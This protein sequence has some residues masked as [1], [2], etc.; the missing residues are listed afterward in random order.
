[1]QSQRKYVLFVLM[2]V[3][4]ASVAI[5]PAHAQEN[6]LVADVPFD[7]TVGSQHLAAGNYR[8]ALDGEQ[9]S[10]ITISQFGGQTAY[11]IYNQGG[12]SADRNGKPYLI[13]VR[14]GSEAFLTKIVVSSSQ[15]Y[16]LPLS[17]REREIMAQASPAKIVRVSAGGGGSR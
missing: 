13:F 10:F 6:G 15:S 2:A 8:V 11:S 3:F 14:N 4:V 9:R 1:M 12:D 17:S 7:F 5:A 16:D